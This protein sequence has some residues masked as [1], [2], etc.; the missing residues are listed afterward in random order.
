MDIYTHQTAN[1]AVFIK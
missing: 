1:N